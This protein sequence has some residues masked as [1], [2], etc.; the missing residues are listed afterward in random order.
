MYKFYEINEIM[1]NLVS[2]VKIRN[3]Q[4]LLELF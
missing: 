4:I 3:K 1:N 2:Y